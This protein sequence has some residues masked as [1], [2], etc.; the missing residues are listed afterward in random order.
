VDQ[1][2]TEFEITDSQF[3]HRVMAVI[4]VECDGGAG[5]VGDERVVA[6]VGPQLRLRADQ[7]L[8]RTIRRRSAMVVSA[9]CAVPP[10]G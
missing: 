10:S 9:T 8:R 5:A 4:G 6:P 3:A 7:P 1:S 2:G